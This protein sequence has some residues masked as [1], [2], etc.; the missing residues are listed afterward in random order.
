MTIKVTIVVPD[1][2]GTIGEEGLEILGEE[3]GNCWIWN[4]EK[5][6]TY[7]SKV[8]IFSNQVPVPSTAAIWVMLGYLSIGTVMFAEWEVIVVI[9]V[10]MMVVMSYVSI[11]I[12]LHAY[13]ICVEVYCA[14]HRNWLWR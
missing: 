1:R 5:R 9:V 10:V 11:V 13:E 7:L 12:A 2:Y 6:K 3:V 8:P 14:W 4:F